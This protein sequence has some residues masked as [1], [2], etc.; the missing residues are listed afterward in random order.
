M[1][2]P[3]LFPLRKEDF[4][5]ERV[6]YSMFDTARKLAREGRP[7]EALELFQELIRDFPDSPEAKAARGDV[8]RLTEEVKRAAASPRAPEGSRDVRR[9]VVAHGVG[10]SD[11]LPYESS[12]NAAR[13]VASLISFVGWLFV[14]GGAILALVVIVTVSQS[15]Y[16]SLSLPLFVPA[17]SAAV[18]GLLLV[19]GGQVTRATVDTADNTAR[20]LHLLQRSER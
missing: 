2:L 3:E 20:V 12:Y 4:M 5:S 8:Q 7:E 16:G 6:P 9:P 19:M 18:S 17:L 1:G 15:R 13:G 14:V 10:A 11:D